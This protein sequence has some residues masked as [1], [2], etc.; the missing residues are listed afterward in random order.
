[1][2][3][4]D[5]VMFLMTCSVL[6]NCA[7]SIGELF[8]DVITSVDCYDDDDDDTTVMEVFTVMMI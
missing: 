1:V 2:M 3:I 8:T 5:D 4:C 7:C 6:V